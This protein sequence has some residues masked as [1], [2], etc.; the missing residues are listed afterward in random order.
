MKLR[1]TITIDADVYRRISRHREARETLSQT[2][3]RVIPGR[4]IAEVAKD[5]ETLAKQFSERRAR[6]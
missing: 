2:M 6:R 4:T 3:R 1:K 5:M